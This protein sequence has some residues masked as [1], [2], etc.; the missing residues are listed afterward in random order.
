MQEGEDLKTF[1]ARLNV[2]AVVEGSLV[3][4][5][6]GTMRITVASDRGRARLLALQHA[7]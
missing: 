1:G 4:K 5:S 7:R 2:E 6:D 3:V